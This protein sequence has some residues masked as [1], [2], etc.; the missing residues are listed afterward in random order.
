MCTSCWPI[1]KWTVNNIMICQTMLTIFVYGQPFCFKTS[2]MSDLA[3]AF[4][5]LTC[6][7]WALP[8]V[9]WNQPTKTTP[10]KQG[11]QA[12]QTF[13]Y[14]RP[15]IILNKSWL[16][17]WVVASLF[18]FF[19]LPFILHVPFVSISFVF[20]CPFHV[21]SFYFHFPS[22]FHRP[23]SGSPFEAEGEGTI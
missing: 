9:N 13:N 6:R 3:G 17:L 14:S 10:H 23:F 21:L 18:I 4:V 1:Y 7:I 16:V 22:G 15:Q 20:S 11:S 8:F 19:H 5:L 12:A 2:W